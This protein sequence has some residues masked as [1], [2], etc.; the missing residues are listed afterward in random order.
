MRKYL[1]KECVTF[2]A[3]IVDKGANVKSIQNILIERNHTEVFLED[4][5]GLPPTWIVKFQINLV[6]G[7]A[8]VAK[9]PYHLAPSKMQELYRKLQ[10]LLSKGLI[11]PSSSPWGAPVL[12]VK[13]KMDRCSHVSITGTVTLR[14][15]ALAGCYMLVAGSD[16]VEIKKL[17]RQLSQEFKMKDLGSARQILGMSIIKD[18]TKGALLLS[19]EKY[20]GKVLEKFNIKDAEGRSVGSVMYTMVC[21]RP[22]IAHAVGVVSRFMSNP[23]REHWE[24]VKWLLCYLK[25]TSKATLYFS[26]KEVVLEGFSNLDYGGC[27]DSGKSTTGYVFTVGGTT[28][29]WM[30]RIQKCVAMS[31][32]EAEYMA[33]VEIRYHYIRELVSEG[34]LS[35]KK[36]LEAKNPVDMFTK[37]V[38]TEKLKLCATSTGLRDN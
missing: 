21:T 12:F 4:L 16:M 13:K 31:T 29:S 8:T 1:E 3:H 37:V 33:I 35:L 28:V 24:A 7:A 10:E 30:S 15:S 6:S 22:Y 19:Q 23:G 25:G 5:F 11:T 36:I 20:I 17:K 38:T 26:R 2:L 14:V 9:A 34:T 27:L 18:K 32:T